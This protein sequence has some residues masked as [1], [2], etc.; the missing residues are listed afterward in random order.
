MVQNKINVEETRISFLFNI[1]TPVDDAT[2]EH[3]LI[4]KKYKVNKD[5]VITRPPLQA[6]I[7]NF[8]RKGDVDIIYEKEKIPTFLGVVGKN[9]EIVVR[10]FESLKLILDGIDRLLVDQATGIEAVITSNI[11]DRHVKPDT[12]LVNFASSQTEEFSAK[13]QKKYFM[14][15]FTLRSK[16]GDDVTTIHIAPL[17]RDIRFFYMQL[18]LRSDSLEKIFEFVSEQETY[19]NSVLEILSNHARSFEDLTE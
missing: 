18:V 6:V 12:N 11:F 3:A 10:E 16:D 7:L 14:D 15:N 13:F 8:A 9:S 5:R 17:Y 19:I 4:S 2:L 1:Q